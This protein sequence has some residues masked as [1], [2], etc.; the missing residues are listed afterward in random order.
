MQ[1]NDTRTPLPFPVTGTLSISGWGYLIVSVEDST[2]RYPG[3][4]T[5]PRLDDLMMVCIDVVDGDAT[6]STRCYPAH[7][8]EAIE[9]L[10]EDAVRGYYQRCRDNDEAWTQMMNDMREAI[11][12]ERPPVE[13]AQSRRAFWEKWFDDSD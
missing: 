5:T 13:A 9:L 6:T 2:H 7:K 12:A 1:D 8:V 10:T 3:Y 11:N 4:I